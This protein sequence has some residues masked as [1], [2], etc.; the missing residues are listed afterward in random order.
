MPS[1]S[2]EIRPQAVGHEPL[3]HDPL[4]QSP[5]L[6]HASHGISQQQTFRNYKCKPKT[7]SMSSLPNDK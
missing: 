4:Q 2:K 1:Q 5:S 7:N 6:L 3:D